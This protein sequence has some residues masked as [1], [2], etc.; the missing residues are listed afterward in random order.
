[1]KGARYQC[2]A[3]VMNGCVVVA[4]GAVGGSSVEKYDSNKNEWINLAAMNKARRN[5]AL[6]I[7]GGCL[8]AM[9]YDQVVEKYDSLK[10]EWQ[11]VCER[12][13]DRAFA[14]D[15]SNLFYSFLRLVHSE[16]AATFRV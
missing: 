13:N 9:G 15:F 12:T 1:M 5:I 3:V 4:G 16:R 14:G 7:S 10:N 8:Y 2:A 6:V 11:M